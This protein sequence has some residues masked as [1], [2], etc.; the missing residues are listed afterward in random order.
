MARLMHLPDR[1]LDTFPPFLVKGT[2]NCGTLFFTCISIK[3]GLNPARQGRPS[4]MLLS[5][6]GLRTLMFKNLL[7]LLICILFIPCIAS[8]DMIPMRDFILLKRGMSEAEVLY[9][10]GPYDYESVRTDYD[11]NIISKT[12]YYIPAGQ[13]SD[14]WITE[15]VID[16]HGKVKE[17]ERYRAR[18]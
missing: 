2:G 17:L 10:V 5:H 4:N 6:K 1:K 16:M 15:I 14:K 9:R 12:W 13:G 8:A 7:P 11:R 3:T 18:R